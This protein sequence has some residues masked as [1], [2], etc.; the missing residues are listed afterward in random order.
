MNE[1]E[2][3]NYKY[4]RSI[5]DR[6]QFLLKDIEEKEEEYSELLLFSAIYTHLK[7]NYNTSALVVQKS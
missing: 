1:H 7:S 6:I 3:L 4:G 5:K 2:K